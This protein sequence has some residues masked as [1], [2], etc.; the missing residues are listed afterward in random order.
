MADLLAPSLRLRKLTKRREMEEDTST[1]NEDL[2]EGDVADTSSSKKCS[3]RRDP[4]H[5]RLCD[6]HEIL[7]EGN[8]IGYDADGQTDGDDDDMTTEMFSFLMGSQ[9]TLEDEE[10]LPKSSSLSKDEL[11][12]SQESTSTQQEITSLAHPETAVNVL[13]RGQAA[14]RGRDGHGRPR[15]RNHL[16]TAKT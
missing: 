12:E 14:K 5:H 7:S 16:Y 9:E 6:W 13:T 2:E 10:E 1:M 4:D 3:G 15:G 11:S 8:E